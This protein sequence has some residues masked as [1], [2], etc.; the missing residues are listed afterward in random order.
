MPKGMKMDDEKIRELFGEVSYFADQ[1]I[2]KYEPLTEDARTF[3]TTSYWSSAASVNLED[4][5][6]SGHSDY[7]GVNDRG[8][9]GLEICRAL[10]PPAGQSASRLA[11]RALAKKCQAGR[12]A[13]LETGLFSYGFANFHRRRLGAC[14][15]K[16]GSGGGNTGHLKESME[17]GC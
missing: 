8:G 12:R 13:R 1:V 7:A 16:G 4:V 14:L 10:P 2:E 17:G 3:V 11:G 15:R 9:G 6:G 5:C